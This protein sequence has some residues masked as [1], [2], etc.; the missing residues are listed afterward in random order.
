MAGKRL[1][2]PK[3]DRLTVAIARAEELHRIG[4]ESAGAVQAPEGNPGVLAVLC[5]VLPAHQ[6]GSVV[7]VSGNVMIDIL[8]SI[9]LA[10][11]QEATSGETDVL[12]EDRVEAHFGV[13]RIRQLQVPD[14]G[15]LVGLQTQRR[16]V[17][18]AAGLTVPDDTISRDAHAHIGAGADDLG[19]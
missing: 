6:H 18:Q 13:A 2:E 11:R 17:A 1:S 9:G 12:H 19:D 7:R 14:P 16:A 5:Q 4:S 10:V 8:R 15:C 3:R